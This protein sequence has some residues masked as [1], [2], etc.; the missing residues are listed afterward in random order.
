MEPAPEL[1]LEIARCL[2]APQL[3]GAKAATLA[4]LI[5]AGFSVPD[6]FVVSTN[7][8]ASHLSENRLAWPPSNAAEAAALRT[9]IVKAPVPEKVARSV[10]T[11]LRRLVALKSSPAVA[12]RSSAAE[13]DSAESS[14]AGQF[15]S[16]LAVDAD[17]VLESVRNCWSSYLSDRSV[18]YRQR[19][20]LPFADDPAFAV[21]VQ[22]QVF[23]RI[24]GVLFTVHP[25]DP[26]GDVAYLEANFGTG[27][28]VAGS[29][30]TPDGLTISRSTG[31]VVE[32]RL[33]SKRRMTTVSRGS[34][35]S[36][37]VDVEESLQRTPALTDS[38]AEEVFA[39]GAG[40]E[41]LQGGPQD[42]EWAFEG[43]KLWI[44]QARPITAFLGT[45]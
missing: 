32:T 16:N 12:V 39:T 42:V 17:G 30:A 6:F 27:E 4:R 26:G 9:Q 45:D 18:S 25:M 3:V 36:R 8:F 20:G 13:E 34:P 22:G 38:E 1:V 41:K 29:L 15:A 40:I 43:E 19:R 37:V 14:F 21:I 44:L 2:Q 23:S 5:D 10:D 31:K 11:A 7:A 24:A 33:G 35:G 28:S